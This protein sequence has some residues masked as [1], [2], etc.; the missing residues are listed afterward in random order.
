MK[1]LFARPISP[2]E[3]RT[4]QR[5]G[6]VHLRGVLNLHAVNR[7][8]Q[9]IDTA[10]ETSSESPAAYD[11]SAIVQGIMNDDVQSLAG[12][13]G[14]QYEVTAM[15]EYIK[16][17]GA[18][19]LVDEDR[20]PDV[21][22]R[23]RRTRGKGHFFLDSGVAARLDMFRD[24]VLRG[25]CGEI[26]SHLMDSEKVNFYD[27]QIFIKEPGALERTSWHQDT[28]YFHVSGDQI[29]IFWIPVDPANATTGALQ[30]VRGS[31]LWNTYYKPNMFIADVTFP[32]SDDAD[33]PDIENNRDKFDII[34][35][36]VEPGDIVV[37]HHLTVHGASGNHSRYQVRRAAS[38][39][40]C[41]DDVR[42]MARP[43]A[44]VQAHHKHNLKDGDA[45]DCAQFP[46]VWQRSWERKQVA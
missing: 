31:H 10:F 7:L 45:I 43:Y 18:K 29:C 21:R 8:R 3:I 13:N 4:Y 41:G 37:H 25:P 28:T 15:A 14:R 11:L 24:F 38:L 1:H 32:G 35:F 5:D 9:S 6:V 23:S 16:Q 42:Y 44:P 34:H 22:V 46:V 26:A 27:D 17:S 39:R 2:D 19:L 33:L 40:Y 20:E 30:Y 12:M 36:N